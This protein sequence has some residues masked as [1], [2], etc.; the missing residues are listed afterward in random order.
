MCDICCY[1]YDEKIN[2]ILCEKCCLNVCEE[3][4]LKYMEMQQDTLHYKCMSEKCQHYL[5][6]VEIYKI[7]NSNIINNQVKIYKKHSTIR[8]NREKIMNEIRRKYYRENIILEC[9]EQTSLH[10]NTTLD[11]MDQFN[12][13]RLGDSLEVPRE[14]ILSYTHSLFDF[15]YSS[16]TLYT[17]LNQAIAK[18]RAFKCPTCQD[19]IILIGINDKCVDCDTKICPKCLQIHPEDTTCQQDHIDSADKIYTTCKPCPMC[20]AEIYKVDGCDHMFCTKCKTFFSWKTGQILDNQDNPEAVKYENKY[21]NNVQY[22]DIPRISYINLMETVKGFLLYLNNTN[23]PTLETPYDQVESDAEKYSDM[24]YL[25]NS[26]LQ[27]L[28]SK[29]IIDLIEE[30]SLTH[31]D[32]IIREDIQ[33]TDEEWSTRLQ[34][35]IQRHYKSKCIIH[36]II[37]AVDYI[38]TNI[39]YLE[40]FINLCLPYIENGT[41]RDKEKLFQVVNMTFTTHF[42]MIANTIENFYNSDQITQ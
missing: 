13:L 30:I 12:N 20:V 1:D 9:I 24:L 42:F 26:S 16:Q 36:N 18:Y 25:T 34:N 28:W 5:Y 29:Y 14:S 27:D 22:R 7:I 38:N 35:I 19:G 10:I 3:C 17:H 40:N 37:S 32:R 21:N 15:L 2:Y 33:E 11:F 8:K 23:I 4:I 6:P 39:V 41:I 31:I